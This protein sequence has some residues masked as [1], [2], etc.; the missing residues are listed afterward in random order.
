LEG[1]GN[2]WTSASR[3]H[4]IGEANKREKSKNVL[5]QV[6]ARETD[7]SEIQVCSFATCYLKERD[8]GRREE[9]HIEPG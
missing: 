8:E 6:S 3:P 4:T 1:D 2:S 7:R 5:H 9:K